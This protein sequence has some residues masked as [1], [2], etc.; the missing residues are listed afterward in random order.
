HARAATPGTTRAPNAAYDAQA[1]GLRASGRRNQKRARRCSAGARAAERSRSAIER[2]VLDHPSH[3][4]IERDARVC[5][6]L[7]Y[8]RGFGHPRLSIDLETD[9]AS[10]PLDPVV[11]TEVRAAHPSAAERPMRRQR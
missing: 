5:R 9:Q 4:L 3:K 11:V 2:G 7:R 1:A 10:R 8:E 6:E